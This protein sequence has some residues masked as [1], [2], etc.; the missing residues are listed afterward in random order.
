MVGPVVCAQLRDFLTKLD[1]PT[2]LYFKESQNRRINL[3]ITQKR[4]NVERFEKNSRR[5]ESWTKSLLHGERDFRYSRIN[6]QKSHQYRL[7]PLFGHSHLAS[8]SVACKQVV[9]KTVL[10]TVFSRIGTQL[11]Y[12]SAILT[13]LPLSFI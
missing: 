8:N 6:S 3:Y 12:P 7:K 11:I 1:S 13:S 10:K 5:R 9:A 2:N 4:V